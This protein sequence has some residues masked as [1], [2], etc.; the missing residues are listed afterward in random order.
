MVR[1]LLVDDH[2][3]VRAGLKALLES[4]GRVDVV[5]EASTGEEAID[6]GADA[7]A[8]HRHHGSGHA[9]NGAA[10]KRPATSPDLDLKRGSWYS[11]FTTRTSSSFPPSTPAPRA[12]STSP[13]PTPISWAPSKRSCADTPTCRAAQRPCSRAGKHGADRAASRGAGCSPRASALRSSCTRT[14]FRP[15]RRPRRCFSA[16]KPWRATSPA[17][18]RNWVCSPGATSCAS[19]SR[20]GLLR[21]EGEQ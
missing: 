14:A 7:G 3:V 4:T 2:N 13:L 12:S 16:P 18:R 11:R 6:R 17:P 15:G 10:S 9:R 19:P 20:P 5:G 8:G 1:V 21:A